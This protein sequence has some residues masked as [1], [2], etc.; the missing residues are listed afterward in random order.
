MIF[1]RW[2][3]L[4]ASVALASTV[5]ASTAFAQGATTGG[6]TGVVTDDAG[7]PLEN[8]QVQVVNPTTGFR[9]GQLTR[10]NGRYFVQNLEVGPGYAVTARL[11]GYGPVTQENVRVTLNQSV[12]ADFQLRTQAAQLTA[13]TVSAT[14][15]ATDFAP[16]RQGVATTVSDTLLRRIPN[17]DRDFTSLVRLSPQVTS[18]TGGFSAAGSNPRLAQ[19]TIDGANQTDRFGLNSTGL[20]PGGSTGG[21][22]IPL[23]AVKEVQVQLTPTDIRL[24][25]FAGVLVNAVTRS[26]TNDY[27]GG[28]N[29]TFRNPSLARDTAFVRTGNLRQQQFGGFL[30]GPIVRDRLHFFAALELQRREAPNSGPSFPSSLAATD[31]VS[32]G[33]RVTP[34]QIA[35]VQG[36]AQGLGIEA[37]NAE[38]LALETP[39]TN[40]V[41]RLDFRVNDQ[42]RFVLRQLVN[43][44]EQLDFS[45]NATP[46]NELANV[47]GTGIR[48]SSNR[49]PRENQN[50]STV[51]QAFTSLSNGIANEFT[52]GYNTIEDVRNPPLASPEISVA[53]GG[54]QITF[55]TEQF[56]P[57]NRLEQQVL[58]LTNNLTVP[59]GA[60]TLTFGGRYDY[61]SIFNDFRQR[62]YG[63]YKFVNIDSLERGRPIGYSVAYANGPGIAA[64]FDAQMFS[65]YAQDQWTATPRITLTGG[66]RMDVPRLGDRPPYN[67]SITSGFEAR[68]ISG[69]STTNTPKT[70]ALLSPRLGVNWDVR[71]NQTVQ[72]RASTGMYTGQPPYIL[73]ANAYQNSGLG[74]AFLNCQ[75][76]TQVP[77]FT[78]DV[79]S[80]PRACAGGTPP[81]QG[82]A[83]TAGV[84]LND[85]N[86]KYPQRFVSTAGFDYQLPYGVVFSGEA[87]YGRDVN[88]LRIRDLN[89]IGPRQVNGADYTTN[90]GRVLYADTITSGGANANNFV[91]NNNNQRV[92]V[93]NRGANFNEGA[94]LVTNQS[95][96]YNY[97]FTPQLRKRFGNGIDLT[98]AYTYT[99]A[100]EVQ[101]FTSDRA[102]SNWRFGREYSGREDADELTTSAY[103]VRHRVTLYG[104]VT[105]PWK[106]LPTDLS[107][108]YQGNAGSPITYTAN[109]DLNGD[110]FNANDPIYVPRNATDPSEIRIV[111]LRNPSGSFNATTNPYE[112]N[113]EAA[114][115]FENFISSN[116]CLNAQRGRIMERNTCRNPWQNLLN[117]SL[118]QTLPE[119]RGNRVSAQLD[120]FNFLNFLNN[121]WG[122]NRGT[123]I[124][125]NP[126]QQALAVRNR[127]PGPISDESLVSYEY[128]TRLND[129]NNA[130][131]AFQNLINSINNVYRMQLTLRYTF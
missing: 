75:G 59:L 110:G 100:E 102:I 20:A 8:V 41:G 81:A 99:R 107:F 12:R 78:V 68:G 9:T 39:L 112:L 83:G 103:E 30:G 131:Q 10:S 77:A 124:S 49:V 129:A 118:R 34:A 120:I 80:L 108:E 115:Q 58:E 54:S 105:S 114:Q 88:G 63:A 101:A 42:T 97:A 53:A 89:L 11:I 38:V 51:F 85:P 79:S 98:A 44:A 91:V 4:G 27:T 66:L 43:R 19:F 25:N 65:L 86:F 26:G 113:A 47:Q 17:L 106:R 71:G 128:D 14:A 29:Y 73:L 45:R 64:D 117:V 122:V 125:N 18:Q 40:F 50:Y 46:F 56:S 121:D 37:G 67:A 62:A 82:T 21:R 15:N 111:R 1:T 104:T 31:T 13:V 23:D 109:G 5:A 16:T 94:L 130:P 57:V 127:L 35:R 90:R 87:I 96:A 74:L 2:V 36:I 76:Y 95:K 28:L 72:L 84:N 22:L 61:T 70:R 126:Q 123:I 69:I 33:G 3:A 92:I 6:I 52:A 48:L 60:H 24:G 116:E 119:V 93:T 7:K 32:G 55:G